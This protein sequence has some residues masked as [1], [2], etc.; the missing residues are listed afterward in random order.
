MSPE[1]RVEGSGATVEEARAQAL[2]EIRRQA[3]GVGEAEIEVQIVE[4]G[5]RGLL[6][7]G[8]KPARIIAVADVAARE[9]S[10]ESDLASTLREFSERIAAALESHAAVT[11]AEE[12]GALTIRFVGGD[13]GIVIGRHG[14]T[15]DAIQYLANAIAIRIAGHDTAPVIA[16]AEGYRDRQKAALSYTALRAAK[17]AIASGEPQPLAPMSALERKIVHERLK[18]YAGVATASEGNEPN[19]YV[20]VAPLD[21]E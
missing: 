4:E 6:G 15:I 20:V 17:K 7:I 18:D 10:D 9:P 21:G 13:L 11:L 8:T 2:R 1:I 5:E 16:D 19:R 12:S 14:Q 3:P